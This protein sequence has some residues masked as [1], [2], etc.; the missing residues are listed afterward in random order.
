VKNL[1]IIITILVLTSGYVMTQEEAPE[2]TPE[3]TPDL[4]VGTV[5]VVVTVTATDGRTLVA[6]YYAPPGVDY[7]PVALL[8]H[9]LYTTGLSWRPL[10]DPLLANGYR[11][12]AVDL[13][14]YG[15]TRG[16]INWRQAQVDTQTWLQW[17]Y[18]QPGM[19]LD[20]VFIVGASMGSN[21]ALVGCAAAE[22]CAGVVAISP[23]LR[24]FGIY[25]QTAITSGIP[26]LLLYAEDDP[27]PA[28]DVP[29]MLNMAEE[30]GLATLTVQVYSGYAHGIELFAEEDFLATVITW[31][32]LHRP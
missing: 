14:G 18:G 12:I 3:V 9:Q 25:T 31:L 26:A 22:H 30:S 19:R 5:P 6:D 17:I 4:P 10:V 2:A 11:V 15:R 28:R 29:L 23:G 1:L 7:A 24:Y 32:N 16:S 13:R 21:L 8:L 20:A 27:Y